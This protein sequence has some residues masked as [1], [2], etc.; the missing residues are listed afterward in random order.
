MDLVLNTCQAVS[1]V[2]IRVCGELNNKSDPAVS[3]FPCPRA[4]DVAEGR[5]S[6]RGKLVPVPVLFNT[7]YSTMAGTG[8]VL[9]LE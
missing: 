9:V 4:S 7:V 6:Q 5:R 8:S 2:A 3:S 1:C